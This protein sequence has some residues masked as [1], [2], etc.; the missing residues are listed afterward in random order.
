MKKLMTCL[1][2][3]ALLA[4][5]ALP[6]LAADLPVAP[7]VEEQTAEAEA[8]A[9]PYMDNGVVMLSLRAVGEALGCTVTWEQENGWAVV[10]N[11]T[12]HINVT[13]GVDSY[14]RT[15]S[16]AIG[17][18]APQSLGAAPAVVDGTIYVPAQLFVLLDGGALE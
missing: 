8:Q 12:V 1:A 16:I 3:T 5:S 9:Q 15:S 18:S 14:C 13:P 11:G 10:D 7:A 2:C 6:A 17:M 4:G